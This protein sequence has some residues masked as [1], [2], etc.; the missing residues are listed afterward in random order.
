MSPQNFNIASQ[1]RLTKPWLTRVPWWPCCTPP[2]NGETLVVTHISASTE[3][4]P[5][6]KKLLAIPSVYTSLFSWVKLSR[7][8]ARPAKAAGVD[9]SSAT[10][11]WVASLQLGLGKVVK[12]L[13]KA[14][15]SCRG[16]PVVSNHPTDSLTAAWLGQ[17][18]QESWQGQPKL[19][20]W[21]CRQP[22]S[23]G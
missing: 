22:S 15:Q 7:I 14:S 4:L 20:W 21:T 6:P 9:L 3:L 11:Q 5:S 12:S 19:P 13:G 1:S 10:I 17:S 18:C 23:N 2:P 8:L 16:G